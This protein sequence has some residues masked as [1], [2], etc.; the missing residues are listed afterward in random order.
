MPK[1]TFQNL[2]EGKRIAILH[3]CF[4]EFAINNYEKASISRIVKTLGIAKG[5]MYQYFENKK[6]LYFYLIDYATELRLNNV[7][8]LFNSESIEFKDLLVSNF[9]EKVQFDRQFPVIGGFL[10]TVMKERF[11]DDLGNMEIVNKRRIMELTKKLIH[12][13]QVTS[14][15]RNDI[16]ADVMAYTVVQVQIGMYDFIE[17]T[18]GIDYRENIRAQ[19]PIITIP[20]KD[21][22]KHIEQFANILLNGIKNQFK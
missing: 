4:E 10:Y 9:L 5:S 15:I 3:A 16:P 2:P 13:Y 1:K 20:E 6:D 14:K 21:L 17:M 12:K 22:R 18:Y 11:A 8:Q 19:K 7:Q